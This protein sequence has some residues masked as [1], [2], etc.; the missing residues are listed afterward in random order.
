MNEWTAAVGR[1][2]RSKG[3][4]YV[5]ALA[6]TAAF[7]LVR[8][9]DPV[10]LEVL[11]LKTFDLY[12]QIKPREHTPLPVVI[13]DLDEESLAA[14]GQWPWP[15]TLVADLV[16]KL[17]AYQTAVVGFDIVFA[18]PDR[19]S[20]AIMADLYPSLDTEVRDR[21]KKL[22][23]ND[24]VFAST[25]KRT[26]VVLGQS[27]SAREEPK[28]TLP[29]KSR[30]A[31][32]GIR[33]VKGV[34]A[35]RFVY[36][37]AG[38][39]RNLPE[40][41]EAAAGIGVFTIV[42]EIDGV[43]RRVPM[44]VRVGEEYYPSLTVEMLRVATGR[45]QIVVSMDQ[46]GIKE[47]AI[48][49]DIKIPTDSNGQTWVHF[50]PHSRDRYISAKDVLDGTV[51]PERLAGK[52]AIFGTSAVGLLDIK[53][54]PV[55]DAMPGVEVH[56]QLL[57]TILLKDFLYRPN[58]ALAAELAV[59]VGACLLLAF[60]VT[61]LGAV[62]GLFVG[63]AMIGALFGMSW[64]LYVDQSVLFGVVY[65]AGAGFLVYSVVT[66][67]NYVREEVERRQVRDA[68]AHYMS[69]ALV[70]QLAEHPER[71][72]LGG[73][74]KDMTLLFA[75][76]RGFTGISEIYKS[77]PEGLTKLINRFLTPM[78]EL[79]LERRGTIDKYMG[80][81][82]MAF[83]NAPLDDDEHARHAC[84]SALVMMTGITE[85]NEQLRAEAE[86]EDRRFLPIKIGIGLN[87]GECCVGNMGSE[88]R[89]DYSVLGDD[90][91]LASRLEGQSK[92]YGVDIVIGE[93]TYDRADDFAVIE[94]DLIKVKGKDEAV[95]IFAL[96]GEPETGESPEFKA[97]A[98]RHQEMLAAY[99]G[100][101]WQE[102]RELVVECRN[103]NGGLNGLYDLY[104]ERLEA[105][106]ANPP[107]K[108]WG[109][110]FVATTK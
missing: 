96:L 45:P 49:K 84:E 74:M 86:A 109:G 60:M 69:P 108:D 29:R 65:S 81:C 78:T 90:V 72:R 56:A 10:P 5:V 41:E 103:L 1:A 42:P 15:R 3:L 48:T 93:H 98:G 22:P 11:R 17:M 7:V 82:I 73:E 99:R 46:A 31:S 83:W 58:Y 88:Q 23:S 100:Q 36:T 77:D 91:N 94:L 75:D 52:L 19:T 68:F 85:L 8:I 2:I 61:R 51:A 71:L 79:I 63:G 21:L 33:G 25:L 106:E 76:I 101:R 12:Q 14:Y 89:F 62:W 110:V 39:V 67:L 13:I 54:T 18:E 57:E 64:Y 47:V 43:V 66:F 104:D 50:S 28:G 70:E 55:D 16:S 97:F 24:A 35:R 38:L 9:W 26:R 37:F 4:T 40:L 27:T 44:I 59:L 6:M 102:A 32:V 20:P 92:T 53:T 107:G 34:D 95:R 80:D 30:K 105:Y 87:S